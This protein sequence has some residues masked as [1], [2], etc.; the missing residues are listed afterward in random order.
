[1]N[2]YW[3]HT[4]ALFARFCEKEDPRLE[5]ATGQLL[6]LF[7]ARQGYTAEEMEEIFRR[8]ELTHDARECEGPGC[9]AEFK[10]LAKKRVSQILFP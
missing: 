10:R 8:E 9:Q 5:Y 4:T 2:P 3:I 6:E 1:M 7:A